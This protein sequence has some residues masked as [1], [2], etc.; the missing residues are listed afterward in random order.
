MITGLVVGLITGYLLSMPPMGPTNIL[1][2]SQGLRHEIRNGVAVGAGAGFMDMIYI[3]ISYG[4]YA[5]IKGFIP[6]SVDTFFSDNEMLFKIILTLVGCVVVGVSGFKL[7]MTKVPENRTENSSVDGM[8]DKL[9]EVENKL[10]QRTED[11]TR[12]LHTDLLKK[13]ENSLLG[14]FLKGAFLCISS[15]TIPASWFAL[16]GYMKSYGIIDSR[17]IT[18]LS[19]SIGVF[20]GTTF[21]FWTLVKVI[22]NNTHRVSP[23]ALSKIN[24]GVGIM[25]ILLSVFL[26]Y[27][28]VDFLFFHSV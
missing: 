20:A 27:K 13:D 5:L 15:V 24:V 25:L 19:Y 7:M 14:S 23:K 16:T 28:A 1:V 4:G 17:F 2:I 11:I 21:W 9:G 12:M 8:H 26:L 18:G 6:D 3:I 10:E 22:S